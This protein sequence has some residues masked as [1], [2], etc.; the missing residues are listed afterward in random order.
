M[1]KTLSNLSKPSNL[2]RSLSRLASV[3]AL[4]QIT[5][6]SNQPDIIIEN[7]FKNYSALISH[8]DNE[9]SIEEFIHFDKVDNNFFKKLITGTLCELEKID[10]LIIKFLNEDWK[11]N[12]LEILIKSILRLAIGEIILFDKT[13]SKVIISEYMEI[14]SAYYNDKEVKMINAILDKVI[15]LHRKN[16]N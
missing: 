4:Y 8:D 3:Q 16:Q 12:R 15:N 11:I 1:N 13:P 7:Y 5:L 14:T 9:D 2:K 6:S 10:S